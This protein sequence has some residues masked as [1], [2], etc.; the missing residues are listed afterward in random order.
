MEQ[1]VD[2]HP[3]SQINNDV[4][5]LPI[6]TQNMK[7]DASIFDLV[8]YTDRDGVNILEKKELYIM[9]PIP[10]I[11]YHYPYVTR[12]IWKNIKKCICCFCCIPRK[13]ENV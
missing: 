2:I 1:R 7:H 10:T 8:L 11:Q 3:S 9:V 12:R 13:Y 6:H 5:V 4:Y